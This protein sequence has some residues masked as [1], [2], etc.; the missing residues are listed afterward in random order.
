[1]SNRPPKLWFY[2]NFAVLFAVA[3]MP[4][5]WWVQIYLTFSAYWQDHLHWSSIIAGV[6]FLPLGIVAGPI[7]VNAG[8]I[9][10]IGQ[11]KRMIL[12][13]LIAAFIATILL[14]FSDRPHDRYWPLDFPAFIIG[15][16]G[17]SIA[18]VLT[19]INIFRTTPSRYAGTVG[20]VFNAALQLGS[21]IGTSATTS[22]QASVD[23]RNIGKEGTTGFEGR[24]A[25][26]W[27]LLAW[28]GLEIIGVAVFFQGSA[29]SP[30]DEE[31]A[32]GK[33]GLKVVVH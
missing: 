33:A 27:F 32:E 30:L 4:Y 6:K 20:A 10:R 26:L 11:P 8:R 21:A 13:G 7:M 24:S 23:A 12:G 29:K 31:A 14:P 28:V 15:T 19:N 5:F 17:T 22:I 18:F 25:A 16:A 2:K 3:L 9:A 1:M